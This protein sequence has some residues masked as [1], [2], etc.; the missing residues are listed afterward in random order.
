MEL[1]D[2]KKTW[3]TL[4]D[5]AAQQ[6]LTSK[7]IDQMTQEKYH[8]KINKIAY[9]EI[10][11]SSICLIAT[12]FIGLNFYQLDTA[13]FQLAGVLSVLVLLTLSVISFLS[14]RYL[15][16]TGDLNRPYAETLKIFATRKKQFYKLQKT[17][18]TLS[19]LLLVTIFILLP[20]FFSGRDITASKYFWIFSFCVGYL[21]LLFFS[22]VV[23][24]FYKNTLRQAEE[25]LQELQ[26]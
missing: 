6:N 18:I 5:K 16:I 17:N 22:R 4:S 10:T 26:P 2:L 25:L 21:F 19:Y 14:L 3:G 15:K 7:I 8:S 13:F 20:K 23:S 12:T 24:R 11:G 1:D 9:P